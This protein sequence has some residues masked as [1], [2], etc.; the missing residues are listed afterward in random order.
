MLN[1]IR[2]HVCIPIK[3]NFSE[4]IVSQFENLI[5][6]NVKRL[7][8][9]FFSPYLEWCCSSSHLPVWVVLFSSLLRCGAAE[10][11]SPSNGDDGDDRH[12]PTATLVT[13]VPIR[14]R[15]DGDVY[16]SFF[17][18]VVLFFTSSCWVVLAFWQGGVASPSAYR[19]V[20]LLPPPSHLPP[21]CLSKQFLILFK[22]IHSSRNKKHVGENYHRPEGG[23]G[24]AAPP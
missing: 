20:L 7:V 17:F 12:W 8:Q 24:K 3:W 15:G 4:I 21:L 19:V 22:N 6:L 14:H 1:S 9:P 13:I 5:E 18:E 23:G 16:P 10:R 11:S 2:F